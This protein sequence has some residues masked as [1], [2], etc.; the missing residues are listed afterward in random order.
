[1]SRVRKY[2][3][4]L[5]AIVD[6]APRRVPGVVA[7]VTDKDDTLYLRA[8]GYRDVGTK[9]DMTTDS[10]FALFSTTK[11]LTGVTALQLR[12]EGLLD[13]DTPAREYLPALGDVL[14]LEGFGDDGQPVLRAPKSDVTTKQLLLHTAGFG[15]KF[16]NEHY[17]RL[18]AGPGDPTIMTSGRRAIRTPLLF[19]PGEQWEYGSSIDWVGQ[20]VEAI[21]GKRLGE[22]M[23]ER[24]LEPLGMHDTSFVVS[25]TARDR[26]AT[27]HQ[28]E[29]DGSLTPTTLKLPDPDAAHNGGQGLYSTV[30]DYLSFIRMWL[31]DGAAASGEQILRPDT[32]DFATQNHLGD[33]KVKMLPGVI[34]T[35]SNNAEFFPGMPK[36]WSYTFMINDE[37][38]PTGR[39][40]GSIAW[41]GLGN[42]YYWI[43]RRNGIGGY[44]ATQILPFMDAGSLDG[45]LEFEKATYDARQSGTRTSPCRR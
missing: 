43:D 9:T 21:S 8:S 41:A 30:G 27:L 16:F 33:L 3:A 23:Q 26:V 11:A 20:V 38:A 28:R 40:A 34:P 24:I 4:A 22:V 45:Y 2:I 29:A 32:V 18:A 13:F 19:D 17:R 7:G 12:E 25:D 35:L 6:G 37:D 14:V 10:I 39:P 36:S 15:Y 44:W 42:L 31:N 5:D 1:M